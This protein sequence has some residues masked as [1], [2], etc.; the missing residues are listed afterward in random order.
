VA[1]H[2]G[3]WYSVV[4][5]D[6]LAVDVVRLARDPL[7]KV[8]QFGLDAYV[9]NQMLTSFLWEL[10]LKSVMWKRRRTAELMNW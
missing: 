8:Q 5:L 2:W 6:E 3:L 7:S 10:H 9:V 1:E 4:H